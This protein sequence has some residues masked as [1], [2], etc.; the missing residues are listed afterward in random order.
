LLDAVGL[1]PFADVAA[2][3]LAYGDRRRLEVARA[4]ASRPRLLL[5]DEPA[6]GMS[7]AEAGRLIELIRTLP[8]RG[9]AVLLVEHNM[10]VV[11]AACDRIGV[12]DFGQLIAEGSPEAIRGDGR[13]IEAYLGR[14]AD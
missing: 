9:H 10:R 4:L 3:S 7:Q 14:D 5:L 12:L 2:A 11:M 6:A 13:V 8:A 1:A